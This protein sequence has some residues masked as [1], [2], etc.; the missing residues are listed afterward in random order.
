[1]ANKRKQSG[2]SLVEFALVL[3]VL[4]LILGG[5]VDLG[6]AYFSYVAVTDAAAEGA[7]YAA[8]DP[9]NFGEIVERVQAASGGLVE[10]DP[11]AVEVAYPPTIASGAPI[12]V[13]VSYTYTV[14]TPIINRM[15]TGGRLRL[16]STATEVILS[17]QSTS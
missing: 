4:L 1:M 12:T 10:I 6:R 13:T 3:P 14:A 2:Q 16:R 5:L 11:D 8:A 15:V 17:T 7:A 9:N